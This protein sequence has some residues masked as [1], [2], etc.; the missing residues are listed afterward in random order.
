ME[1]AKSISDFLVFMAQKIKDGFPIS[2]ALDD[3]QEA[4][5]E[6]REQ[7]PEE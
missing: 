6:W 7:F 4:I 2:A 5:D 3:L 1:T